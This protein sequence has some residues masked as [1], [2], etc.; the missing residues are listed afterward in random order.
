MTPQPPILQINPISLRAKSASR[1]R[2]LAIA[3]NENPD[4][5]RAAK[6]AT[7][8]ALGCVLLLVLSQLLG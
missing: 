3:S 1:R 4:H 6:V 2:A 5:A 7:L 8:A